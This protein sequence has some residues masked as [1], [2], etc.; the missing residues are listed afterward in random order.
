M[1]G[2]EADADWPRAGLAAVEEARDGGVSRARSS[3]LPLGFLLLVPLPNEGEIPICPQ[4]QRH[5]AK[6][7]KPSAHLYKQH[8]LSSCG[9]RRLRLNI[10]PRAKTWFCFSSRPRENLPGERGP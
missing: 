7:H 1:S 5:P 10:N 4:V 9:H 3:A 8:G 6:G 2:W